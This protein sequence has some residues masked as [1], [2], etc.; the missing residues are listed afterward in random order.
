MLQ[1]LGQT[2]VPSEVKTTWTVI[3]RL[4]N[5]FFLET[6]AGTPHCTMSVQ[7]WFMWLPIRRNRFTGFVQIILKK[8]GYQVFPGHMKIFSDQIII[9]KNYHETLETLI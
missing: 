3:N 7:D 8:S 5:S 9:I 6:G 1:G 4:W 2:N